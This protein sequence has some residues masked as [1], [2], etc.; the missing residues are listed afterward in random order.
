M[1][2]IVTILIFILIFGLI[3]FVHEFGHFLTA[4]RTGVAV[5]E[6]AFGFPPKIYSRKVGETRYVI[7]LLPLG[8]YVKLMG[9]DGTEKG[10]H[11]FIS[12]K[13]R[14]RSVILLAGIAMNF[15]LAWVLLTTIILLPPQYRGSGAV[16]VTEVLKDTSAEKA[17]IKVGDAII[18]IN[19]K[20][21]SDGSELHSITQT[22]QGKAIKLVLR[23]N[24]VESEK[25]ITLG[26]GEA[27]LGI[28]SSTFSLADITVSPLRA[29]LEAVLEIGRVFWGYCLF[30]GGIFGLGPTVVSV[31]QVSGPV[32][33]YSVVAQFVALG[34]VYV[35]FVTAQLS[36]AIAFF[37]LLP[38]PAL[39]GGRFFFVVLKK[40]FRG[41]Y[42]TLEIEQI[43]HTVGFVILMGL[44]A[45]IAYRDILKLIR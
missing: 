4:K 18:A 22:D 29:P 40:L 3:V 13:A 10:P 38:L 15:V 2:V 26:S 12:K 32:G 21:I 7:N 36:L 19:D 39:D 14:V 24:G 23:R 17:G 8:G 6:F 44:F 34:W 33:I 1:M 5:E 35:L 30:I 11:S 28:A 31:D 25:E 27:P 9:E 41:K 45:V 20:K 43:T 42:I 37:N 16:F